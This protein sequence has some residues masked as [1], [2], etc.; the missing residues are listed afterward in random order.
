MITNRVPELL[1]VKFGKQKVNLTRVMEDTGLTYSTVHRWA[2]DRVD[3]ADFPVLDAW[4]KYFS[5]DVGDLLV[6]SEDGK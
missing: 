5:C 2:H 6:F 4:C 3:R 1:R